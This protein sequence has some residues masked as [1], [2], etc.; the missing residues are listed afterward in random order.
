MA[1]AEDVEEGGVHVWRT[2]FF[3]PGGQAWMAWAAGG[4]A[5]KAAAVATILEMPRIDSR[6][7]QI[8][9][10]SAGGDREEGWKPWTV[11][12]DVVATRRS[13]RWM[14]GIVMV[15]DSLC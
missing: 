1:S 8:A 3:E 5:T 15:M 14:S 9:V 7:E 4:M 2:Q 11:T 13:K 6:R 10:V 12:R